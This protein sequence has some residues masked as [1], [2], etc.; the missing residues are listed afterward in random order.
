[1]PSN[2]KRHASA[3]TANGSPTPEAA[4]APEAAQ[5]PSKAV[6]PSRRAGEGLN[7]TDLKDMSIQKLTQIAKDMSVT[8]ATGMRKQ[9]LIFQILKAQTEQSGFIF[10][11][12]VLEVL[13][14][15]FGFLRAPDYNYL[16][17][18]DDIYVSPSQIRKFDLQ[19][20][21]T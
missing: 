2:H 9:E 11:D 6:P 21:D 20:G 5:E 1:M 18:P 17:G 3:R 8:G 14:D 4:P 7:I 10:S 13:P 16:P 19:T 15:G 12:G